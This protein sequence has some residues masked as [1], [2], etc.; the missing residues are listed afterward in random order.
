MDTY[1]EK[2][3]AAARDGHIHRKQELL[4]ENT[5]EIKQIKCSRGQKNK[6]CERIREEKDQ[7]EFRMSLSEAHLV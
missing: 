7:E 2:T 4:Q 5:I 6:E 3:R 1:T